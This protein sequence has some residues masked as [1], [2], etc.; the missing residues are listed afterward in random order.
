MIHLIT[1]IIGIQDC[2]HVTHIYFINFVKGVNPPMKEVH[3]ECTSFHK[4]VITKLIALGV[5]IILAE[6]DP[7]LPLVKKE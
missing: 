1:R 5:F 6:F 4:Y 3:C 7:H 2:L